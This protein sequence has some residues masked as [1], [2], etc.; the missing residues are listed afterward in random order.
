M[1]NK[2]R[3]L[4]RLEHI[5]ESVERI[6]KI[7]NQVKSIE[8][9]IEKWIEQDA[10]IRNFEIIGEAVS[11][12]SDDTKERYPDLEWNKIRGLRNFVAHEYYGVKLST[13]WKTATDNIPV[14]KEQIQKIIVD[15]N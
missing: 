14:L 2:D 9:F 10:M 12:I 8:A 7:V 11:H 5:L 15:F 13:I 3:D 1:V 4:F 6:E